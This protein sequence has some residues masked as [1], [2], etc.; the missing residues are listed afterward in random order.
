MIDVD[1][2]YIEKL[3]LQL[4]A[5]LKFVFSDSESNEIKEFIDVGEYGLALQTLVDIIEEEDKQIQIGVQ[6]LV[7][8]LASAMSLDEETFKGKL[9]RHVKNS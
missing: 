9:S 2:Q 4:L 7:L 5:L 1:F 6:E 3:F 8:E